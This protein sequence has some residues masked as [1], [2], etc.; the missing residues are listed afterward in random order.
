MSHPT[1]GV[2]RAV[3]ADAAA[4][5]ALRD[6]AARWLLDRG[7][8]QWLP[9]E[10]GPEDVIGWLS[11][12][13]LYVAEVDGRLAGAVRLAWSDP[14]VWP[15]DD[16]PAAYVQALVSARA[17]GARG[18]GRLLLGRVEA[19][20]AETGRTRVRLSCLHGNQSLERFYRTAGYIIVGV[21][22][23]PDQPT[24]DPVT[25]MEKRLDRLVS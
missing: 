14:E 23:F 10:V 17:P 19:I 13:R 2:R 11:G 8:R 4:V 6:E 22:E 9:G 12:G 24:W 7:I 16:E 20:A 21:Q 15:D 18:V 3:P 5:V 1:V 25:L